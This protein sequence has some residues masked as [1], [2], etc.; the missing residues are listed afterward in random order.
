M[1][2]SAAGRCRLVDLTVLRIREILLI[3]PDG[4]TWF[5]LSLSQSPEDQLEGHVYDLR[6]AAPTMPRQCD[7]SEIITPVTPCLECAPPLAHAHA[8]SGRL[9]GLGSVEEV[10]MMIKRCSKKTCRT[11][12]HYNYKKV[13]GQKYHSLDLDK[14]DYIFVN[15]KLGFSRQFLD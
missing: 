9:S 14:T 7:P 15:R 11:H 8:V 13:E 12:H 5:Q 6:G 1:V 2:D 4:L 10:S 3:T